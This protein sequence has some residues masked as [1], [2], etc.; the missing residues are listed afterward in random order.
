MLRVG[1]LRSASDDYYGGD[2]SDTATFSDL[3]R[4]A[5]IVVGGTGTATFGTNIS[6]FASIEDVT[7]T[8]GAD[9]ISGGSGANRLNGHIGNDSL[10][11]GGNNDTLLGDTGRDL[12]SIT[13][14]IAA[15]Y[16]GADNDR[17][18]VTAGISGGGTI[19]GGAGSDTLEVTS[20]AGCEINLDAEALIEAGNTVALRDMEIILGVAATIPSQA[21]VLPTTFPAG[22]AMTGCLAV[23]GPIPWQ[24]TTGM[25]RWKAGLATMCSA[26]A[27]TAIPIPSRVDQAKTAFR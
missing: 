20:T 23:Q 12:L 22:A 1:S 2:G 8:Q 10:Y 24:A 15:M 26:S 5:V 3:T 13:A 9:S 4:G 7:G 16:G 18:L 27:Q 21:T 25:T 14:G 17:L 19:N 6:D 11:G